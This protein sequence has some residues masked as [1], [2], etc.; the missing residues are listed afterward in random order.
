M[1]TQNPVPDPLGS[2]AILGVGLVGGSLALAL[3]AASPGV[4][5]TGWDPN[6]TSLSIASSRCALVA[7]ASAEEAAAGADLVVLCGP[8]ASIAPTAA[9]IRPSLAPNAIVTDVASVKTPVVARVEQV[10]GDR[11]VGGHPMA[12]SEGSGASAASVGMFR[13]ATWILTPTAAT[14][15]A[16]VTLTSRMIELVGAHPLRTTP[17]EHDRS[18]AYLSHLPHVLAYAMADL[19]GS[20]VPPALKRSGGGSLRDGTRVAQSS[21]DLW[22][23]ILIANAA[24]VKGAVSDLEA[25]CRTLREAIDRRDSPAVTRMLADARTRRDEIL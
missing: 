11:Y 8:T 3:R 22:A 9:R 1:N 5:L 16:A 15:I 19:A 2:V 12:G 20:R 18:V 17:Q 25:W 13:N 6:R 4:R 10:L 14:S 24:D 21:A 7:C 23:G